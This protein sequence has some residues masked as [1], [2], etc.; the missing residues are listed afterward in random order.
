MDDDL[1]FLKT[2]SILFASKGNKLFL[3]LK[4]GEEFDQ[5]FQLAEYEII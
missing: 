4:S 5:S 1:D 2:G 3:F